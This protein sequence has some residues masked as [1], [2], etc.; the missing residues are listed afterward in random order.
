[1]RRQSA[2][3]VKPTTTGRQA[4]SMQSLLE[5][6]YYVASSPRVAAVHITARR[7]SSIK[8]VQFASQ[9]TAKNCR[10]VTLALARLLHVLSSKSSAIEPGAEP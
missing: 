4:A 9:A 1:M 2:P 10:G 8:S 5:P 7:R 3:D 6:C